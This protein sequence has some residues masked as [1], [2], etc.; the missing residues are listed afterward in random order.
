MMK[1][2]VAVLFSVGMVMTSD[3]TSLPGGAGVREDRKQSLFGALATHEGWGMQLKK[4]HC[5]PPVKPVQ[6]KSDKEV[7]QERQKKADLPE[8]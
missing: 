6:Q 4:E 2:F 8:Q 5:D 7:E 3:D 1:Y